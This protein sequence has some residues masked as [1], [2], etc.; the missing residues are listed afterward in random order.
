MLSGKLLE[1]LLEEFNPLYNRQLKQTEH[2]TKEGTIFWPLFVPA[3]GEQA[4][5]G[6][7][8]HGSEQEQRKVPCLEYA[9]PTP[10]MTIDG[11]VAQLRTMSVT[12]PVTVRNG[13]EANHQKR[14]FDR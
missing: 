12:D 7:W 11:L 14:F 1:T 4:L 5:A 2:V 3:D 9:N 8:G 13:S 10:G 6:E